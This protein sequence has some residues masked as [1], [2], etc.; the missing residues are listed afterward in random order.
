MGV[1][2]A[3]AVDV[4]VGFDVSAVGDVLVVVA[5]VAVVVV[6]HARV[7]AQ[8][9]LMAI[10][11]TLAVDYSTP[12][13]KQNLSHYNSKHFLIL[14]PFFF[15]SNQ[16]TKLLPFTGEICLHTREMS[17]PIIHTPLCFPLHLFT[18]TQFTMLVSG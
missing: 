3:V 10:F 18:C 16:R 15:Y 1:G 11:A 8:R 14:F 5:A 12:S 13:V 4:T 2:V 6:V 9:M 7:A 17:K